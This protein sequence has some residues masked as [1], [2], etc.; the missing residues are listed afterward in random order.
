MAIKLGREK[1]PAI[2]KEKKFELEKKIPTV[3]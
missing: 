2:K 1:G 3:I